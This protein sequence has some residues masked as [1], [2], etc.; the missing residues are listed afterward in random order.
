MTI[1]DAAPWGYYM[2]NHCLHKNYKL[3]SSMDSTLYGDNLN[4]QGEMKEM[5]MS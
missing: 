4:G 2:P 3:S 1:F 5:K